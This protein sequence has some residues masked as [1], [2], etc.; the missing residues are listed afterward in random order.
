MMYNFIVLKVNY[1][2]LTET[3][4]ICSAS[5]LSYTSKLKLKKYVVS[6]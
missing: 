5:V 6:L 2:L 1:A 4:K 3:E